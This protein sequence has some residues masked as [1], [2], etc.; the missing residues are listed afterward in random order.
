MKPTAKKSSKQSSWI[1]AGIVVVVLCLLAGGLVYLVMNDKGGGKKTFVAKVDLVRPNVPDRPPPPPKE[2]LPEPEVRKKETI[3]TP[4]DVSTQQASA[5]KGDNKPAADGPLGLQGDGSAGSDGFGLAAR[6]RG[7][8]DVTTVGTGYG[9]GGEDQ[10]GLLRKYGSYGR[11]IQDELTRAVRKR[12]D[13]NGGIPKGKLE[14]VVQIELDDTGSIRE[15]KVTR[16]SGNSTMDQALK[17]S[18]R[19]VKISEAPPQGMRRRIS[20]RVASQG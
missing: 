10:A 7:G 17:D 2:K 18:S 5:A 16:S 11:L 9:I 8:K 3:V 6:G 4:T 14:C 1:T 15:C 13:E 20:I 19:H 12:L